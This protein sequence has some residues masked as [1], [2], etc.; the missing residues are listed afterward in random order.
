MEIRYS[1][2]RRALEI[3]FGKEKTMVNNTGTNEPRGQRR[4][5]TVMTDRLISYITRAITMGVTSAVTVV[6]TVTTIAVVLI[7][8]LWLA[9]TYLPLNVFYIILAILLVDILAGVLLRAVITRRKER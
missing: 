2:K 9:Y 4:Y 1:L 6:I 7:G 5:F 8:G 3:Q